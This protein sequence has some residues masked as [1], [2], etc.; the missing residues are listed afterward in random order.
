[1]PNIILIGAGG[2]ARSCIDV[3][4]LEGSHR[5]IGLLDN[6][7]KKTG[8]EVLGHP[9]LGSD[10]ILKTV[11]NT[12]THFL[13]CIGQLRDV[14]PR[15][16]V[17]NYAK[18]LGYEGAILISPTALVS[19]SAT[20][21]DG[22]IVMH[23]ATV[24]AGAVIGKNCI[25][26]THAIIEHDVEVEDHCHISTGVILNGGVQIGARSFIGSGSTLSNNIIVG[27]DCFIPLGTRVVS[28]VDSNKGMLE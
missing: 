2:H 6:C 8:E 9:V 11:R 19:A 22:T 15:V 16:R 24:N 4:E 25:V 12:A 5:I 17:F 28:H 10:E 27:K 20:I 18:E 23:G 14:K 3:L 7:A 13:V 1:M 26:N 21:G